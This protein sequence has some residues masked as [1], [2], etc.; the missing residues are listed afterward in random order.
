MPKKARGH[1]RPE[2]NGSDAVVLL[3]SGSGRTVGFIVGLN[4][5]GIPFD[6]LAAGQPQNQDLIDTLMDASFLPFDVAEGCDLLEAEFD[7]DMLSSF[8]SLEKRLR[9]CLQARHLSDL[10]L[11]ELE[12]FMRHI[13]M[14][15]N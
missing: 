1:H 10:Q 8:N 4:S 3:S 6:R 15:E 11:F 7:D 12:Y 14:T 2:A 5:R 9:C 13:H